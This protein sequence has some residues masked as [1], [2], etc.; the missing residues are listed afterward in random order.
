MPAVMR[1]VSASGF[2]SVPAPP[3]AP[4]M[5]SGPLPPPVPIMQDLSARAG[6]FNFGASLA[7]PPLGGS[8]ALHPPPGGSLTLPP[9][10]GSL[11]P[12]PPC[13]RVN[14]P[15]GGSVNLPPP[16]GSVTLPPAGGSAALPPPFALPARGGA[17]DVFE[18]YHR[19]AAEVCVSSASFAITPPVAKRPLA[20]TQHR[21]PE[22]FGSRDSI[23]RSLSVPIV[24]DGQ[25]TPIEQLRGYREVSPSPQLPLASGVPQV[26]IASGARSGSKSPAASWSVSGGDLLKVLGQTSQNAS[27]AKHASARSLSVPIFGSQPVKRTADKSPLMQHRSGQGVYQQ[28]SVSPVAA[29]A[30]AAELRKDGH[31]RDG[32]KSPKLGYTSR[33]LR[34]LSFQPILGEGRSRSRSSTAPVQSTAAYVGNASAV[35]RSQVPPRMSQRSCEPLRVLCYGDSNTLPERSP[36]ADSLA[37]GLTEAGLDVAITS[38]GLSGHTTRQMVQDAQSHAVTDKFGRVGKGLAR[39]LDDDGHQ[40]LVILMAGTNDIGSH[41]GVEGIAQDVQKLQALCLERNVPVV[42]LAPVAPL[43][44]S[45]GVARRQ[46]VQLLSSWTRSAPG[47]LAFHDVEELVPRQQVLL[48]DPDCIHLTPLGSIHLGHQL[49]PVILS[50]L[51]RL[52]RAV[53]GGSQLTEGDEIEVWSKSTQTWCPGR[54]QASDGRLVTAAFLRQDGTAAHKMLLVTSNDLRRPQG[55]LALSAVPVAVNCVEAVAAAS[56]SRGQ[57]LQG[58]DAE[59][60]SKSSQAWCPGCVTQVTDKL[61]TVKIILPSGTP[62]QKVLPMGHADLRQRS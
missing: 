58:D 1:S 3:P 38:C 37:E 53:G 60:W 17:V 2:T 7:I 10:V 50:L 40:D 34:Q 19:Q 21:G 23:R 12:A 43:Q 31:Q 16:G 62:A 61:V 6:S 39:I 46:L 24:S 8:A 30:L 51:P 35:H 32:D 54:V 13:C 28:R 45:L 25:R 15:P 9:P 11:S 36:Y 5:N 33:P 27:S 14:L 26:A 18:E 47:V 4:V 52:G 56:R 49:V 48:Y 22:A 44:G 41:Y 57:L 55:G 59:V 29:R 42:V 20:V